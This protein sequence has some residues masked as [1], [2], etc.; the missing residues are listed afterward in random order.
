MRN[1]WK[2]VVGCEGL[3]I[4]MRFGRMLGRDGMQQPEV[5]NP[6]MPV[7]LSLLNPPVPWPGGGGKGTGMEGPGTF[8]SPGKLDE[9]EASA[10]LDL[11]S[12]GNPNFV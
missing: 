5:S 7:L 12:Q 1:D 8:Q 10:I 2:D 9:C 4:L 6:E 3:K 11:V